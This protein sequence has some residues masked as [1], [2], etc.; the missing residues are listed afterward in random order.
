MTRQTPTNAGAPVM[1]PSF[2]T[3]HHNKSLVVR[4]NSA[5]NQSATSPAWVAKRDRHMQLINPR[6]YKN[7]MANRTK[8][9]ELALDSKK[10]RRFQRQARKAK[11]LAIAQKNREIV[12]EN[13]KFKVEAGGSR[14]RRLSDNSVSL[15][16]PKVTNV[17]GVTFLRSKNGNLWRSGL[18]HAKKS[19]N[20]CSRL[21]NRNGTRK[22]APCRYFS[23]TGRR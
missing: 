19:V 21:T 18:L 23:L 14:L 17:A 20:S 6:V 7:L 2:K 5:Q 10:A 8:N 16:T 12:I 4:N 15:V 11:K 1:R 3:K 9:I 22:T 13:I